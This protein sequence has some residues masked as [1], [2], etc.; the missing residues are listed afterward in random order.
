MCEAV[1]LKGS[2]SIEKM[3]L[4]SALAGVIVA[5]VLQLGTSCS[6]FATIGEK[7]HKSVQHF[8]HRVSLLPEYAVM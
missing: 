3:I 4:R 2:I 8:I 6:T 5:K 7:R 1:D